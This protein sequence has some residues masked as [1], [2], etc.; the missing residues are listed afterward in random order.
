M[1]EWLAMWIIIGIG[2]FCVFAGIFMACMLPAGF[3]IRPMPWHR[4]K[5]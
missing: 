2:V 5:D 4:R 1:T 3:K